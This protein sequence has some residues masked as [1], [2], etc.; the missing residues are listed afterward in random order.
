MVFLVLTRNGLAE[1]A[2]LADTKAIVALWISGGVLDAAELAQ[3]RA[4]GLSV[5]AFSS[6]IATGNRDAIENAISTIR[7]HHPDECIWMER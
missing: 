1:A 4:T 7:E 6:T 3:L 5:S 2:R